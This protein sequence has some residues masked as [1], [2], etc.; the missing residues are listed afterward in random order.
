MDLSLELSEAAENVTTWTTL[1]WV[2][3]IDF[4]PRLAAASII[5]VVGYILAS[6]VGDW[7]RRG[8]RATRRFD[9]TLAPVLSAVVKYGLLIF[10]VVSALGQLG[11]Q[12]TSVLAIV[13]AAGLAIG[14]AL[15]GTLSNIAAGIMLLWLRPFTE[16]D[17]IE[18][19]N[20]SG[21]VREIGL[22]ATEFDTGDGVFRFVPN[23]TLWNT[24]LF[25]YSRNRTRMTNFLIGVSYQADLARARE[26]ILGAA[27]ADP[28]IL[29]MPE[30]NAF[31]DSFGDSA[32]NIRVQVWIATKE[33][34]PAQRELME[35]VKQE[36]D[37]AG[38]DI[39]F[40]QRVV[41]VV[42]DDAA[43]KAAKTTAVN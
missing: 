27:A 25:N 34:W 9:A 15:Q 4:L 31:V 3:A 6:L 41:R 36:L 39:P 20:V 18:T 38:L 13:G 12:T 16:G 11:V 10:V 24:P 42:S 14:L 28:R 21:T 32:V 1:M 19:A 5:F 43:V 37:A 33:F 2:W 40:P 29:R 23:S 17:A 8:L 22:F 7:A 30:P 35:R 26:V